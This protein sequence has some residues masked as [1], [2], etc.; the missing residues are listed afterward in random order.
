[1]F[2]FESE[3]TQ[4]SHVSQMRTLR[5]WDELKRIIRKKEQ[6]ELAG[7]PPSGQQINCRNMH[8]S[9]ESRTKS[10]LL[11]ASSRFWQK[12]RKKKVKT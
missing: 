7:E 10:H 8:L 1:M 9:M 5:R 3:N 11:A 12:M 2:D 4:L 6:K